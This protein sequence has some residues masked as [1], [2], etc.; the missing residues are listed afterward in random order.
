M[1]LFESLLGAESP[2]ALTP[3]RPPADWRMILLGALPP[4]HPTP[5]CLTLVPPPPIAVQVQGLPGH[6]HPPPPPSLP[7]LVLTGSGWG[8]ATRKNASCPGR[9]ALAAV[10]SPQKS[11][12]QPRRHMKR[13][14]WS[15]RPPC[16]GAQRWGNAAVA[17]LLL[18]A[19][20]A[21][22]LSKERKQGMCVLAEERASSTGSMCAR[23]KLG[24]TPADSRGN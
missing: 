14:L 23:L 2:S 10:A 7:G 24:C 8:D 11:I 20:P 16:P 22:P 12:R 15:K 21:L 1:C 3:V 13:I 4:P 19:A 5:G 9:E 18:P 6:P 17:H